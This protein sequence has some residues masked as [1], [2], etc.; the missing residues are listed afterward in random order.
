L[1]TARQ[2]DRA[3]EPRAAIERA[4]LRKTIPIIKLTKFT[5]HKYGA[6]K[7]KRRESNMRGKW[8]GGIAFMA[9]ASATLPAAAQQAG[10]AA[11]DQADKTTLG[12][13]VVTAMRRP[14][15]LREVPLSVTAVDAKTLQDRHITDPSE[16][17]YAAPS[18]QVQ[19]NNGS[20]AASFFSV[21]GIGT[22]AF[23][24][25]I[26]QSVGVELDGVAL[27]RPETGVL[28]F[29]DINDVE[30]LNGP[31]GMLFGKN[32]SAGLINITT[33][34]PQLGS[35]SGYVS[36]EYGSMTTPGRG[37]EYQTQGVLNIPVTD[38][39]ALRI[40]GVYIHTDP[41]VKDVYT[42]IGEQ[43]GH[44]EGGVRVKYLWE[45]T[46]ALSITLAGDVAASQGIGPG[47]TT[48]RSVAPGSA[49]GTLDALVG[50]TP[51]PGN[52]H[53]SSNAPTK[54][55]FVSGGLQANVVY[56]LPNR[57][58]ITNILAW[59]GYDERGAQDN[60]DHQIDIEDHLVGRFDFSQF[61]D[62]FRYASPIGQA[63]EYQVG[64]YLLHAR[65]F[66][67][68]TI[69]ADLGLP[70]PPP[71][72]LAVIGA[73][74]ASVGHI[75]SEAAFG[76]ATYH[77]TSKLKFLAGARFTHDSAD[78][79]SYIHATPTEAQELPPGIIP[80]S[81][82]NHDDI[83]WRGS[84]QY[85]FTSNIMGYVTVA[86]GYK[87]PG[88][89]QFSS[90]AV[91]P[92]ISYQYETGLK[93]RLF[94]SRLSLNVSVY[95][96]I[97]DHFQDQTYFPE[98]P[99]YA[100]L[101]AGRLDT[102][103]FEA[104]ADLRVAKGLTLGANVAYVDAYFGSFP[105]D[106]CYTG[107]AIGASPATNVC[108]Q[109]HSNSSGNRL[110]NAPKWTGTVSADYVRPV[111]DGYQVEFN[112]SVY[113]RSS[114]NFSSNDN[115][116]TIQSAYT[117]LALNLGIGPQNGDWKLTVFCRNCG[118]HR[119]VTYIEPYPLVSSDY[120]QQFG[121]DSFRTVGVIFHKSF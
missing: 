80:K 84:V 74:G 60:D 26:E 28:A 82:V 59:R 93:S 41:L 79:T 53:N 42:N 46:S 16:M 61:S 88:F 70:P 65:L 99:Y 18:L 9:L 98:P 48:D 58:A 87:G 11:P 107:E 121:Q 113:T 120:G 101:S 104:Q 95:D 40:T 71:P 112:G 12:E 29:Y 14:E 7:S 64:G 92:E 106:Q 17:V 103:G 22:L 36:G 5:F 108:Y 38:N 31:Q 8:V 47:E 69:F 15:I 115:P 119:F 73:D 76:Q 62:E 117:L 10:K 100:V 34:N 89:N 19:S 55:R 77:V 33:R 54:D 68:A 75:D 13:V 52:V 2:V 116:N 72:F 67:Q 114:V 24:K 83:S 109:N 21:R 96:E 30:V 105:G 81:R 6:T 90:L 27:V 111:G 37:S 102:R 110:A 25:F 35:F 51:G 91:P 66:E 94:D 56:S 39:S 3:G 32:A 43:Y 97:F 4:C 45:P 78:I 49:D 57:G 1:P 23:V 50:V 63:F 118:D 20:P 85:D 86:R 44:N